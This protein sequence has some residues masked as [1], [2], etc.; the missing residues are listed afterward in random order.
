MF[1]EFFLFLS[2]SLPAMAVFMI[3]FGTTRDVILSI[4]KKHYE[5]KA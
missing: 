4:F 1:T 3:I 2:I 5:E